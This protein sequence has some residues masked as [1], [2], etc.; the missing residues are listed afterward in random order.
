M[1]ELLRDS[2]D[3]YAY[4]SLEPAEHR[5]W[6][7]AFDAGDERAFCRLFGPEKIPEHLGEFLGYF[8]VRKV[9]AG[10]ELL[11][12]AGTVTNK[13]IA[14]LAAH[15]YIDTNTADDARARASDAARDLPVAVRLAG[16]LHNVGQSAPEID[17]DA[18]DD[19]GWAEGHLAII[20]VEPGQIWFEGGIRP[21]RRPTPGQ[22]PRTT[23]MVGIDHR[24]ADRRQ[25]APAQIGFIYP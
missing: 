16:L 12:A 23:R 7:Q 25:L 17:V 24:R 22:R 14:W 9:I 11:K 10:Q 13:L 6:E 1:L 15:D 18:L 19:H 4:S 3:S 5:R 20:D 8:M 2:L 21:D